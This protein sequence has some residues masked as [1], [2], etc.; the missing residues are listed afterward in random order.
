MME[1]K[2][3]ECVMWL[4]RPAW[5]SNNVE[6][7]IKAVKNITDPAILTEIIRTYP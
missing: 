1:L 6:R 4:F 7:A 2:E 3:G 5:Q